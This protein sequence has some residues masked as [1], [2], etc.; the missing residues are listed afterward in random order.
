MEFDNLRRNILARLGK[1]L[2]QGNGKN[3]FGLDGIRSAYSDIPEQYVESAIHSLSDKGLVLFSKDK[4]SIQ[5]TQKGFNRLQ[6][7]KDRKGKNEVVIPRAIDP[8]KQH[9]ESLKGR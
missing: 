5:L 3:V 7:V 9:Q 8:R 2:R 6:V 4:Q 1:K